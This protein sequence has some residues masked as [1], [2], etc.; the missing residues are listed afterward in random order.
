M[1]GRARLGGGVGGGEGRSWAGV[2]EG[3]GRCRCA[4]KWVRKRIQD[5]P[6]LTNTGLTRTVTQQART[7]RGSRSVQG[8]DSVMSTA[9]R[10]L[11]SPCSNPL[12]PLNMLKINKF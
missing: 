2:V 6:G 5:S 7:C 3:R 4:N 1:A 10:Q 9:P 11:V 12:P 8:F